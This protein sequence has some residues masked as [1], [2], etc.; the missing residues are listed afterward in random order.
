VGLKFAV[1]LCT[2]GQVAHKLD[3]GVIINR[4]TRVCQPS[5]EEL[6][7]LSLALCAL[8]AAS[9]RHRYAHEQ[10]D[11]PVGYASLVESAMWITALDERLWKLHGQPYKDARNSDQ[12]G[13]VVLGIVWAR[14]RHTHQLPVTVAEDHT[15]F[16]GTGR[17]IVALSKGI[18]WRP[19]AEIPPPDPGHP[20]PPEWK[21]AYETHV[22]GR[23]SW[24]PISMCERWFTHLGNV[25]DCVLSIAPSHAPQVARCPPQT[26][27]GGNDNFVSGHRGG[28]L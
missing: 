23:S 1:A 27:R 17:G 13:Q 5:N 11:L 4:L 8:R 3:Q 22:A 19:A 10:R 2:A 7:A 21:I 26:L 28:T 9:S 25:P 14:D 15:P 6:R 16:F 18:Y 24:K 12:H 20:R